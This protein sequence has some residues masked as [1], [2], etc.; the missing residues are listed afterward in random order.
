MYVKAS[1]LRGGRAQDC[2]QSRGVVV[3]F[4]FG[5]LGIGIGLS[6]GMEWKAYAEKQGSNYTRKL[7]LNK[8]GKK[9]SKKNKEIKNKAKELCC[10]QT[11]TIRREHN[12]HQPTPHVPPPQI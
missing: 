3:L 4:S 8:N 1:R 2:D 12:E 11:S 9:E 7:C 5:R 10:R 6:R